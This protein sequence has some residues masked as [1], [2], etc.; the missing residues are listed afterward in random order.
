[1]HS[2]GFFLLK[3]C[4]M[5]LWGILNF[6]SMIFIEGMYVVALAPAIMAISGL[7]FHLLLVILSISD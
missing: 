5:A 6:A 4:L 2:N 7:T 1:M 3:V